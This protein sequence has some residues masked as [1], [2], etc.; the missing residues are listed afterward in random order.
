MCMTF[1]TYPS[2]A[3]ESFISNWYVT[4][5]SQSSIFSSYASPSYVMPRRT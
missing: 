5:F 3:V 4:R 2:A 1:F